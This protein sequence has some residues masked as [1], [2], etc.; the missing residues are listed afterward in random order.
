MESIT[1]ESKP[2]LHPDKLRGALQ[3][4]INDLTADTES[5]ILGHGFDSL[6]VIGLKAYR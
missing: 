3:A 4:T 6:G 2:H 5:I 1:L